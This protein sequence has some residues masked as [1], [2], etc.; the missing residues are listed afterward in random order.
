MTEASRAMDMDIFGLRAAGASGSTSSVP[1]EEVE[2]D[3][4]NVLRAGG[5][6]LRTPPDE[7]SA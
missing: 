1:R 5:G 2:V 3:G 6:G 7:E 4:K